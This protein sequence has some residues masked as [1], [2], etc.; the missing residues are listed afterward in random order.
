[1]KRS[2]P[3]INQTPIKKW[4]QMSPM[5]D[6]LAIVESDLS[7]PEPFELFHSLVGLSPHNYSQISQESPVVLSNEEDEL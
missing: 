2:K 3:V 6:E 1:M 7:E 4:Q 5:E